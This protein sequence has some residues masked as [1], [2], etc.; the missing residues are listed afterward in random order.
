MSNRAG[1]SML[2]SL[3]LRAATAVHSFKEY[4]DFAVKLATTMLDAQRQ[5]VDTTADRRVL[6]RQLRETLKQRRL[7][8]PLFDTERYTA[9]F[10]S[11]LESALGLAT[12]GRKTRS[13]G[14]RG[15]DALSLHCNW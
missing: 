6:L 11:A 12:M 9:R 13:V 14:D 5:R 8:H 2:H 1:S 3:D 15:G 4:V 7:S 10:H